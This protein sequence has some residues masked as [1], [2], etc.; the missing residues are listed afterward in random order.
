MTTH[1]DFSG[2]WRADFD[3]SELEIDAPE[4]SEFTIRHDDPTW[5]LSRTHKAGDFEDTFTLE[6]STDGRERIVHRGEMEIR[7]RCV[8][9]GTSLRFL[10]RILSGGIEAENVVVYSLSNDGETLVADETLTS[11]SRSYHNRWVLKRMGPGAPASE[12]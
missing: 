11:P 3:R 2:S 9:E 5:V 8:W 7:C 1:P 10:S 6:L 12:T 4:S